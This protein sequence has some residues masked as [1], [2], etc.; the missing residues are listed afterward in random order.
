MTPPVLDI[1][2]LRI[3]FAGATTCAVDGVSLTIAP[4]EIFG[5]LG[6]SGSGKS[7]T[8]AA[9]LRVEP[10]SAL[11]TAARLDVCG[12]DLR[13]PRAVDLRAVRGG[14]ASMIFQEPMTALAPTRT[15]GAQMADAACAHGARSRRSALADAAQDLAAVNIK[16]SERVLRSYPHQLSGGMR[17]RVLIAMAFAGAPRLVIADEITTAID[18][19]TRIAVLDLLATRAAQTRSAILFIS[20]DLGTVARFCDRVGVMQAGRIVEVGGAREV[21]ATP[22]HPYTQRL[23]ASLPGAGSPRQPLLGE[24]RP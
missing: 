8:A 19:T 17:Q 4:N 9:A 23:K 22:Q 21:M 13:T 16:E 7:L 24:D 5:L 20:H 6:E 1:A 15:I 2:D 3:H 10:P 14:L 11:L 12:I 18:P